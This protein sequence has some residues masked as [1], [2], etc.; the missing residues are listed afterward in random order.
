[1]N[2][3]R[4][5][6]A[7]IVVMV[8][9]L[10]MWPGV[11]PA[12]LELTLPSDGRP[13]GETV[14]FQGFL[15]DASTGEPVEAIYAVAASLYDSPTGGTL[16][17]GPETHA[18]TAVASG[19]FNIELGSIVSP[20]PEFTTPPYYLQ[21][22]VNGEVLSP[23]QKLASVPWSIR[24]PDD[25]DWRI[26][27]QDIYHE[28]GFVNIGAGPLGETGDGRTSGLNVVGTALVTGL[29]IPTGAAAGRVLTSDASG[30][31]TWQ[32]APGTIGG[33]GTV[34]YVPRFSAATTL[35]DSGIIESAG[36]I[37][38][39]TTA[40]ADGKVTIEKADHLPT[41]RLVSTYSASGPPYGT[42]LLM[43]RMHPMFYGDSFITTIAPSTSSG[44]LLQSVI[45]YQGGTSYPFYI[46]TN[47]FIWT[48]GGAYIVGG[49]GS[50]S[51]YAY[52]IRAE[53]SVAAADTR[54][55]DAQF[56][57]A[58]DYDIPAVYGRSVPA[59]YYGYG[60]KFAGG[61]VGV[62]GTV[63]AT[64][65][66]HYYGVHGGSGGGTGNCYGVTG[67]ATG[68]G[69]NYGVYGY[70]MGDGKTGPVTSRATSA[71]RACS[72]IPSAASRSTIRWTLRI[73]TSAT[74]T[75]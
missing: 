10:L 55:I 59:D 39:G 47:G 22:V 26:E 21:I 2:V 71:S 23:R 12:S 44:R 36:R 28:S 69:T 16:L 15:A 38:I 41:L 17:W 67:S 46:T 48:S 64:G 25:G 18:G 31:G 4:R 62:D 56:T 72:S 14:W 5:A 32:A 40:T 65:S 73:A 6:F 9:A 63:A 30:T 20:L 34:G 45:S 11:A 57:G 49:E 7:V 33:S 52:A 13:V 3:L 50:T 27:G 60:G 42:V 43:E 70:A 1:M 24:A 66:Y 74:R 19:W 75:W 58:G 29:K 8:S 68:G 53:E 54:V 37:G 35:T 51:P 61:Y